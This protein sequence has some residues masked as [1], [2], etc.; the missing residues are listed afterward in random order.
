M[1]IINTSLASQLQNQ[2]PTEP[3][4]VEREETQLE[5]DLPPDMD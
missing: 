2:S 4:K 5:D 1:K 3:D